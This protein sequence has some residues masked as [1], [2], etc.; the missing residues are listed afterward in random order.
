M[1]S[2]EDFCK[3]MRKAEEIWNL[4]DTLYDIANRSSVSA[5]FEISFPTMV[6]EYLE[7]LGLAMNDVNHWIPY[8]AFHLEFGKKYDKEETLFD[9]YGR[10]INIKTPEDLYD[11]LISDLSDEVFVDV[12]D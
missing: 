12:N 5:M 1:I 7:V 10:P 11:F 8:W 4:Q 9:Y 2:K 6:D 3:G